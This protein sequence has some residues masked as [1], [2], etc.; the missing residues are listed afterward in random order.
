MLVLFLIYL[1]ILVNVVGASCK[2]RDM[3]RER[4]VAHISE[5][6]ENGELTSGHGLNQETNVNR[7]G[8]THWGSVSLNIKTTLSVT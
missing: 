2:R 4:Q 7:A 5:A 1:V 3:L 8:E 6:L